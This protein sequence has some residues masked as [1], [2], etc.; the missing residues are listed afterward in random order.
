MSAQSPSE[1]AEELLTECRS[2][3][4][5]LQAKEARIAELEAKADRKTE[6]ARWTVWRHIDLRH[7]YL[8]LLQWAVER[9]WREEV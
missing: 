6:L 1:R 7:R 3:R 9:G 5:L 2:L 4:T 8:R